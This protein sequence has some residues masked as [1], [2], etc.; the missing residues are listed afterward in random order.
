MN[1][2]NESE[3]DVELEP[4]HMEVVHVEL[5]VDVDD[6]MNVDLSVLIIMRLFTMTMRFLL[7]YF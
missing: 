6:Y 7:L 2:N 4:E 5:N 1:P 3:N